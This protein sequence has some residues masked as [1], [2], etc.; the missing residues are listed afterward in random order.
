M[1]D[2]CSM[3]F[4][5]LD[6]SQFKTLNISILEEILSNDKLKVNSEESIL[7]FVLSIYQETQH[8]NNLIKYIMV[9]NLSLQALHKFVDSI[10]L[11]DINIKTWGNICSRL[12]AEEQPQKDT[13]G[14]YMT[15]QNESK[16]KQF[17]SNGEK[18]SF[19]GIMRYLTKT[20]NG[21]IHHNKTIQITSNSINT[22][23]QS[24]PNCVDFDQDNHYFSKSKIDSFICFDFQNKKI[25]LTEYEI[26]SRTN[27]YINYTNLKNWVI[28]GLND[29]LAWVELDRLENDS[30]LNGASYIKILNRH[31]TVQFFLVK[32]GRA[33]MAIA[34]VVILG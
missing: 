5:V 17:S 10:E 30:S 27:G 14:R 8:E 6:K 25:Q 34:P 13:K 20:T 1:I 29:N 24:P 32:L 15:I 23:H 12:F 26:K 16:A 18:G 21:N 9:Q 11:S 3:N 22:H 31:F 2:F 28:E 19:N 33:G 7:D 4:E